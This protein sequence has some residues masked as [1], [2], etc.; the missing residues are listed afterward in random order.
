VENLDGQPKRKTLHTIEARPSPSELYQALITAKGCDYKGRIHNN[1]ALI[2]KF[3]QRDVALAA[4]LYVA[5]LRASEAID[6]RRNSLYGRE[7]KSMS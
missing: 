2:A 3:H 4:L 6:L 1:T 5:E 7:K